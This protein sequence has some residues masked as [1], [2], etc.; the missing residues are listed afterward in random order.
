MGRPSP[1]PV[2]CS[3][4]RRPRFSTLLI[5]SLG[6]A[7][8]IISHRQHDLPLISCPDMSISRTRPFAGIV[9]QIAKHLKK[10]LNI[11]GHAKIAQEL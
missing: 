5:L 4:S 1:V 7:G 8:A 10:I 2:F 9:Q 11:D 6:T 3:S